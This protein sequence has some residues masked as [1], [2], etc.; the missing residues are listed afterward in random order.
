MFQEKEKEKLQAVITTP[1]IGLGK[2]K[3]HCTAYRIIPLPADT[4]KALVTPPPT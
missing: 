4:K 3:L 1:H 2:R